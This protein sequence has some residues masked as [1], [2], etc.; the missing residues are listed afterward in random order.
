MYQSQAVFQVDFR[1]I[2]VFYRKCEDLWNVINPKT[3][4]FSGYWR[5]SR[6]EYFC[7]VEGGTL[8]VQIAQGLPLW[9]ARSDKC[10][11]KNWFPIWDFLFSPG[12]QIIKNLLT[13]FR[14][15][16]RFLLFCLFSDQLFRCRI[17]L[18]CFC[19]RYRIILLCFCFSDNVFHSPDDVL[20]SIYT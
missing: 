20:L 1:I 6:S 11:K 5:E 17:I 10:V 7:R 12:V 16:S 2:L 9:I 18:S 4:V 3:T 19:S 8:P 15:I 14:L 13:N